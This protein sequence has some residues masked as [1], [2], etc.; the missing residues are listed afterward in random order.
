MQ[1]QASRPA[2]DVKRRANRVTEKHP[3]V[4]RRLG[5]KSISAGVKGALGLCFIDDGRVYLVAP[6][7]GPV[8]GPVQSG[9]QRLLT[10]RRG[11]V[12]GGC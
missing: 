10:L 6:V 2:V 7:A 9:E 12:V 5:L 1:V 3:T 11:C 8:E 4:M